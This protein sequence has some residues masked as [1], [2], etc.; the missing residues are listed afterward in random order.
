MGEVLSSEEV[1]SMVEEA[2][3]DKKQRKLT[4]DGKLTNPGAAPAAAAAKPR[5]KAEGNEDKDNVPATP[6][7]DTDNVPATPTKGELI[8]AV[9]QGNLEAVKKAHL[10]QLLKNENCLSPSPS[11]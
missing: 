4:F 5:A 1:R 11:V 8:D 7:K 6:T 9:K 10:R 3:R 2:G